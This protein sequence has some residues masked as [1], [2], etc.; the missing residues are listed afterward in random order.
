V[1]R[2]RV[3]V[4]GGGP[5]GLATATFL[6]RLRPELAAGE[7]V[8]LEKERYPREKICAGAIGGR[9]EKILARYGVEVSCP[10][11]P[12][13]GIEVVFEAGVVR[14]RVPGCGRVVRRIEYDAAWARA[15]EDAGVEVRQGVTVRTV[16]RRGSAL[17][18]AVEVDTDQ[19]RLRAEVVVGADGV[20]SVV[21]AALG[22]PRGRLR[23]Q[24]VEVDTP[25]AP[26]DPP[27]DV[28]RFDLS[29]LRY[30]GYAWDFPT[31]VAGRPLVSRGVYRLRAPGERA[32][33][34]GA[35]LDR[36]LAGVGIDPAE[37]GRRRRFA[38]R[39]WEPHRPYAA[40]GV[41]LV[42][43]A[44][45][46][47]GATGEGIAQAIQYGDLAARY[48]AERLPSAERSFRDWPARV[49]RSTL[50]IDLRLRRALLAGL[51]GQERKAAGRMVV[52]APSLLH[53]LMTKFAGQPLPLGEAFRALPTLGRIA[54]R[55]GFDPS[56]VP[57]LLAPQE[58]LVG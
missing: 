3:V 30:P 9:A 45:G 40:P 23:A 41:L 15:A 31:V 14:G 1:E 7:V 12:F 2:V 26:G 25:A 33:D 17:A 54:L 29:D 18:P 39:A 53:V 27:R 6:R 43:E 37:A 56:R 8:V 21:R 50:G 11:A 16:R 47:D 4:V 13:D 35:L 5:A 52:A 51:Y 34:A 36:H 19:G 10:E 20:G 28:L 46:I 42:G 44:A 32:L 58:R 24:A 38:E 55:T 49:A 22:V 48:L 57:G